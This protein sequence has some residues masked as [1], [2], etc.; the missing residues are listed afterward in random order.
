MRAGLHDQEF[1]AIVL[2]IGVCE[3]WAVVK[4]PAGPCTDWPM[5]GL[6]S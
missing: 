4:Y 2:S 5:A 1:A 3:S 6:A